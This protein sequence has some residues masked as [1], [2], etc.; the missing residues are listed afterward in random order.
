MVVLRAAAIAAG[1]IGLV[2]AG[3]WLLGAVR[4]SRVPTAAV[5][6][7]DVG[8]IVAAA[9]ARQAR[10]LPGR[11]TGGFSYAPARA[12]SGSDDASPLRA[13]MQLAVARLERTVANDASPQTAALVGWAHLA[14]GDLDAGI[15]LLERSLGEAGDAAAQTNL[16][17]AYL[18]RAVEA[19]RP[20][21]AARA[22][23]ASERARGL[24]P[25]LLEAHFNRARAL[26]YLG[27]RHAA[28]EAWREYL[29]HE[30]EPGWRRE[31]AAAL[32]EPDLALPALTADAI[33]LQLRAALVGS[34][35]LG[36]DRLAA[37]YPFVAR[38]VL[39]E[40]VLG[41]WAD[42]H[43][44]DRTAASVARLA[45]ARALALSL[46]T[47]AQDDL[48][49]RA[50]DRLAGLAERGESRLLRGLAIAHRAYATARVLDG[51]GDQA[52]ARREYRQAL[53]AFERGGSTMAEWAR[54]WLGVTQYRSHDAA[55]AFVTLEQALTRAGRSARS[56][57]GR[58][59]YVQGLVHQQRARYQE[60]LAALGDSLDRL[61]PTGEIELIAETRVSLSEIFDAMGQPD[62]AWDFRRQNLLDQAL[63]QSPRD[64]HLVLMN[65]V[66]ATRRQGLAEA[67][68]TLAE[69][70]AANASAWRHPGSL[71]EVEAARAEALLDVGARDDALASIR[72]A[73]T[74]LASLPDPQFAQWWEPLIASVDSRVLL[75]RDPASALQ[76]AESGL[77]LVD[78]LG[79][80][81][82]HPALSRVA[83]AALVRLGRLD[84]ADAMLQRG[85]ALA[86]A[87]RRRLSDRELRVS[88]F[89]A[90]YELHLDR[91]EL[92]G[93]RHRGWEGAF[94]TLER[95]R[96]ASMSAAGVR[97]VG[98]R[99]LQDAAPHDG[100]ILYYALLE[101]R[102]LVWVVSRETSTIV[103]LR[104]PPDR[105][106]WRVRQL[107]EALGARASASV[108]DLSTAAHAALIAPL[109]PAIGRARRLVIV[110]DDALGLLPFALLR[111]AVTGRVLAQD[112][113]I[114]VAPNATWLH[115]LRKTPLRPSQSTHDAPLFV[116]AS[117]GAGRETLPA[118]RREVA[119][120]STSYPA[121]RM[122]IDAAATPEAVLS[123]LPRASLV[124]VASHAVASIEAP[125]L[126]RLSLSPNAEGR[127]ELFMYQIVDLRMRPGATVIL[128]A[129]DTAS[130]TVSRSAGVLGLAWAFLAAGADTVVGT[131]W[132]VEDRVAAALMTDF[133]RRFARTGDA[134]SALREAQLQ[135]M[136]ASDSNDWAAFQA[137]GM[138]PGGRDESEER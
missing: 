52:S 57:A 74:H 99:E 80:P 56:L 81:T 120:A 89:D 33:G 123:S 129:C 88:A 46:R 98:L 49:L 54:F 10:P 63:L 69:A 82:E 21:D 126:S 91:V 118:A 1:G 105:V 108:T 19:N 55:R 27:L 87:E 14:A 40:E 122:L 135:L 84:E 102:T 17:A 83:A 47:R 37:A 137:I 6:R 112:Y 5:A 106:R 59:R 77:A 15:P 48:A 11:L 30:R 31:A 75:A 51:R 128:S 42:A 68:L 58:V 2:A 95:A 62:R 93:A 114:S 90:V 23:A 43:L 38:R 73:R 41:E 70:A 117:S 130:G 67:S 7:V 92:A 125:W 97:S 20:Q 133:H 18:A 28:S 121:A 96:T 35:Q 113:V 136:T 12:A 79:I 26:Q 72:R 127:S 65:A 109:A 36:I 13:A 3:G 29:K 138:S 32:R 132:R 22:L 85:I 45:E 44:A 71:L 100:V 119:A 9:N 107:R 76:V 86:E 25:S 104:E 66:N 78:R 39:E 94:E 131:L 50:V 53:D 111:D 16:S 24:A 60:A 103:E 61:G 116:A 110:P 64:R 101:T 34:N 8:E 124:H 134:V 4:A 115:R